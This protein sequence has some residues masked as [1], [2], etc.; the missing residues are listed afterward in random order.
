MKKAL[1]FALAALVLTTFAVARDGYDTLAFMMRKSTVWH[2]GD[3]VEVG[4]EVPRV[5]EVDTVYGEDGTMA[6]FDKSP[7]PKDYCPW[8]HFTQEDFPREDSA[9]VDMANQVVARAMDLHF[10]LAVTGWDTTTAHNFVEGEAFRQ[11]WNQEIL[12]GRYLVSDMF[13]ADSL[14]QCNLE[15]SK[16]WRL[17]DEK[18]P[19]AIRL[20]L[21]R[22]RAPLT[23]IRD[24]PA[25]PEELAEKRKRE[26]RDRAYEQMQSECF[27]KN[28]KPDTTLWHKWD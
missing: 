8:Q 11:L 27:Q 21:Q 26:E 1:W 17:Y 7:P 20:E 10:Y 12:E 3:P 22:L 28:Y 13:A 24:R 16:V 15:L 5:W 6:L 2:P 14:V 4:Y 19:L 18:G 9:F 23:M 25:T